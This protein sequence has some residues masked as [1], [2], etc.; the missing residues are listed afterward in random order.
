MVTSGPANFEARS[1]IRRTW[2]SASLA[3]KENVE[4]N[5][6][7]G[8]PKNEGVQSE[9]VQEHEE[10]GDILQGNFQDSYMNLTLK[11]VFLLK[12]LSAIDG[13]YDGLKSVLKTDDDCYVNLPVLKHAAKNNKMAIV[14]SVLG[15][16]EGHI[17]VIRAPDPDTTPNAEH[18]KWEIPSWMY[19]G[20]HFPASVSGSGYLIAISSASCM[21]KTALKT[22]FLVLEDVFITGL[23]SRPCGLQLK[24]SK[25]FLYMGVKYYCHVDPAVDVVI[26]RVDLDKMHIRMYPD[27]YPPESRL[28][29]SERS[30]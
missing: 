19:K 2:G 6:V 18:D 11:S 28:C 16:K 23:C 20:K 25:A 8:D 15:R 4:V 27:L 3:S 22:P 10:F 29:V 21:Y 26:H 30:S 7:L 5:F 13:L 24:H 12:Y 9:V 1:A 14:G 17:P